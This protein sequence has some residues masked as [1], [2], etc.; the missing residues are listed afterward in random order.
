MRRAFQTVE[1]SVDLAV[2]TCGPGTST[3][4][5]VDGT[6]LRLNRLGTEDALIAEYE[7]LAFIR[8][9]TPNDR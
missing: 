4:M 7:N 8:N 1:M 3:R 9:H 6:L 2:G 5:A